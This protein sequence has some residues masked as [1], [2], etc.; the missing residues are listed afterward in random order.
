VATSRKGTPESQS[1]SQAEANAAAGVED[2]A[3]K[4]QENV[5]TET[6][7]GF[8]G[9]EIDSTP[10]ENYTVAGVTGG[11]PTPET[12]ADHADEVAAHMRGLMGPGNGPGPR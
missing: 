9:V 3:A 4:V 2:V 5:D 10:N 8:R 12:D 7:Q 1:D 6:E 11:A